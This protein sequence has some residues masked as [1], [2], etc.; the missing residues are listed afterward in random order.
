MKIFPPPTVVAEIGNVHLGS[1]D[2]AKNLAKLA[3]L[4][5]ADYLKTQKRN[6]YESTPIHMRD[7]PHP[8]QI[9]AHGKT[10]LEH[11]LNLELPIEQHAELKQY[12]EDI[13][14]KYSSSVWDITS[15]NEI[16]SLR[17][18]FIKIPSACN[19]HFKM[20]KILRDQ[21]GGDIHIS[22]GMTTKKERQ[23]V[24]DFWIPCSERVVV[25]HCTSAYPCP[26]DYLY[27]LEIEDLK[28]SLIDCGFRIGFSNH[29]YGIAADIS[30]MMLGAEWIERHF[31]DDRTICHSDAPASLEP[32]G[33]RRLCRD[34]KNVH[35]ALQYR[36]LELDDLEKEQRN[37]LKFDGEQYGN[38]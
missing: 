37:K 12:C 10:Y 17:P 27:L 6:P 29:G 35:R 13:G 22:F 26:F 11:R 9:F 36:P 15:A 21:Y 20:M 28:M 16:I 14:I 2:R 23:D 24:I 38:S 4:C 19:H 7:K 1:L 25:Y 18:D 34:L 30:A 33:L 8:N 3:K 31:V 32:D 5:D